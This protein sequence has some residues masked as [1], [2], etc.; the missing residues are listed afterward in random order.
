[1]FLLSMSPLRSLVSS[2]GSG[3]TDVPM[4]CEAYG[5]HIVSLDRARRSGDGQFDS[6]LGGG[7]KHVG[8]AHKDERLGGLALS[9]RRPSGLRYF[10]R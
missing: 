2:V 4:A 9:R 6:G 8:V 3:L 5:K 1:M 10:L 7:Q